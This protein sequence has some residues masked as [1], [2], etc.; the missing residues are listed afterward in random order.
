M[1]GKLE[2]SKDVIKKLRHRLN[3]SRVIHYLKEREKEEGGFS[4][5]PDLYPNIEDT[6]YAI[7]TLRLMDIEVDRTNMMK[8]LG[9]IHWKEIN[10]PRTVYILVYLHRSLNI[11]IPSPLINLRKR[12][13]SQQQTL[14][15]QYYWDELQKLF[16]EPL[17]KIN[18][19]PTLQFQT[20][21]SLKALRKKI[22]VL[23]DRSIDFNRGE[24]IR[25][26]QLCQNGDGGF[27]FYP[28]T[29]SFMENTYYGLEILSN[30]H[31]FPWHIDECREYILGCQTKNGGFGRAP[32]SFPFIESTFQAVAGLFLLQEMEAEDI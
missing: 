31:A 29:T 19:L 14:D 22:S 20:R 10:F 2:E 8:Y 26:V 4:F 30:L 18:F 15:A 13:W 27:G 28:G 24:V 1:I 25:W 23:L 11:E 9:S 6:Y 7:R 16:N 21:E 5:A 12:D 32:I 3:I 17:K